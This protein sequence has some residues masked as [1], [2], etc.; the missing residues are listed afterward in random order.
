MHIQEKLLCHKTLGWR[1]KETIT[2]SKTKS[3]L[4][5]DVLK[6][7]ISLGFW[8]DLWTLRF[9]FSNCQCQRVRPP[10]VTFICNFVEHT[11]WFVE[12]NLI[13]E[14]TTIW[15]VSLHGGESDRSIYVRF[16]QQGSFGRRH[17]QFFYF[18]SFKHSIRCQVSGCTFLF[19]WTLKLWCLAWTVKLKQICIWRASFVVNSVFNK[20][21]ARVKRQFGAN[22]VQNSLLVCT[23]GAKKK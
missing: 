8:S 15:N 7:H 17:L 1:G 9:F 22:C 12:G 19:S 4:D 10:L 5:T 18:C 11:L 6:R 3:P 16:T 20:A 14:M 23:D 2:V 21:H 13:P